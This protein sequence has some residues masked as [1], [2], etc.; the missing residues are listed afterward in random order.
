MTSYRKSLTDFFGQPSIRLHACSVAQLCPTLCDPID[1]S[2][3]ASSVHR[4]LQARILEWGSRSFS[5]GSSWPRNR[6]QI[7]CIY[8]TGRWILYHWATWEANITLHKM[9]KHCHGSEFN[10]KMWKGWKLISELSV[11]SPAWKT[12]ARCPGN[13]SPPPCRLSVLPETSQPLLRDSCLGSAPLAGGDT[14]GHL[15][16]GLLRYILLALGNV[17]AKKFI[18]I[19]LNQPQGLNSQRL[20]DKR[21]NVYQPLNSKEFKQ[22]W[23]TRLIILWRRSCGALR[24]FF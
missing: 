19:A 3:P 23:Q 6:T 11:Y 12:W 4:I 16:W 1:C 7:S 10:V 5:R 20:R 18:P 14:R 24:K 22:S 2:P 15:Q 13:A 8:C 9:G 21:T 17:F